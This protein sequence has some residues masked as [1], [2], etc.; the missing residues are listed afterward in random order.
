MGKACKALHTKRA[1]VCACAR[2][3]L[4]GWEN[5]RKF[6]PGSS[7]EE[8]KMAKGHENIK[9]NA[10]RTPEELRAMGTKGGKASAE[11]RK[12]RKLTQNKIKMLL[13]A[14]PKMSRAQQKV[15][16]DI[17]L[18]LGDGEPLTL[19]AR[20][21]RAALGDLGFKAIV[22][23]RHELARLGDVDGLADALFGQTVFAVTDV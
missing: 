12:R 9:P 20:H 16:E 8:R 22:L 17:G 21:V 11:A 2:G 23:R 1:P 14:V 5:G 13:E 10:Q 4:K 3:L 7:P 15:L 6:K 18:D 19:P